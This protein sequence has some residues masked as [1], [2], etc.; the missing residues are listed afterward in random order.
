MFSGSGGVGQPGEPPVRGRDEDM[1][2]DSL[3]SHERDVGKLQVP[4]SHGNRT[5]CIAKLLSA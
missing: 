4:P 2:A 3:L 5:R 1:V